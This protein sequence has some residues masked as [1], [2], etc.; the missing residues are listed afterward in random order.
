MPKTKTAIQPEN[1]PSKPRTQR[2]KKDEKKSSQGLN[3]GPTH[4][5]DLVFQDFTLVLVPGMRL[6]RFPRARRERAALRAHRE[7][8]AALRAHRERRAAL[9]AHRERR[10][11]LRAPREACGAAR[12]PGEACGAARAPGEAC[13]ATRAPRGVRRCAHRERRAAL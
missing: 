4:S 5:R 3:S 6:I 7:R 9:R 1:A 12:A 13:G 8:R 2:Q 11:A 10:A